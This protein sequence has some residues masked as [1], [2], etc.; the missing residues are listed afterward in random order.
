MY[1]ND[2]ANLI[3]KNF[4]IIC[5]QEH[6]LFDFE[7]DRLSK[8]IPGRSFHSRS[9]DQDEPIIPTHRPLC[10]WGGVATLW[11]HELDMYVTRTDEGNNRV[12]ATLFD[13]PGYSLCIINCYLPSGQSRDAISNYRE[14]LDN[15]FEITMKFKNSYDILIIGDLIRPFQ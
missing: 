2:F 13:L 10:G 15:I 8:L 1:N 9:V 4:P 6:W 5:I 3:L 11:S 14:D 12:L 7:K